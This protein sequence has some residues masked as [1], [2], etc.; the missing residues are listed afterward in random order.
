MDPATV[1]QIAMRALGD[2]DAFPVTHDSA[3]LRERARA[4]QPWRAYAAQH[5]HDHPLNDQQLNNHHPGSNR[6]ATNV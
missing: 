2:P 1:E 5:L 3:A 6:D 4:W